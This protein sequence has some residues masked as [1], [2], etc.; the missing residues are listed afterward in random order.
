MGDNPTKEEALSGLEN[1]MIRPL[2]GEGIDTAYLARKHKEELEAET[3]VFAKYEGKIADQVDVIDWKTR[4]E[5]RKDAHKL[6]GDYPADKK[7]LS[8]PGGQPLIPP[9]D[10]KEKELLKKL[11]DKLIEEE[12]RKIREE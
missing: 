5:A 2:E 12:K 1:P 3:T 7:E 4:Q 6:R 11:A 10:P 8:G 9:T